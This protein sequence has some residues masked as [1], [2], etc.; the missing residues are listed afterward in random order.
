VDLLR[1]RGPDF[2]RAIWEFDAHSLPPINGSQ[3]KIFACPIW[4]LAMPWL[5]APIVWLR[6]RLKN[7]REEPRGFGVLAASSSRD[8]DREAQL[9]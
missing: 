6:R 9:G 2:P 3:A 5:I 1:L 4:C 8:V 7:E